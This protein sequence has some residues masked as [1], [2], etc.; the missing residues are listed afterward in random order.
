MKSVQMTWTESSQAPDFP[1]R[2]IFCMGESASKVTVTEYGRQFRL[3]Y[4]AEHTEKA[5]NI[6]SLHDITVPPFFNI[7]G[8]LIAAA[9][10]VL[11]LASWG[12]SETDDFWGLAVA[13]FLAAFA[14]GLSVYG[15]GYVVLIL[16]KQIQMGIK[17]KEMGLSLGLDTNLVQGANNSQMIQ[18][19]FQN[20]EYG[21]LFE[22]ALVSGYSSQPSDRAGQP[23]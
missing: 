21:A 23:S 7:L 13:I 2:C 10:F 22:R 6:G 15:L 4:C 16:P 12:D 1:D 3:P 11:V 17:L 20:D 9:V 18:F 8:W 14:R 19:V 5:R